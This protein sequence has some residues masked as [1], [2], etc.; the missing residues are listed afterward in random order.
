MTFIKEEN[1]CGKV[2]TNNGENLKNLWR[3]W[4]VPMLMAVL[5][6]GAIIAINGTFLKAANTEAGSVPGTEGT[7]K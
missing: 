7:G 6:S 1:E 5:V 3:N 4:L 2:Y